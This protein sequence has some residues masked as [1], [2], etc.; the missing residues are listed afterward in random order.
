ME[1]IIIGSDRAAY[2]TGAKAAVTIASRDVFT[3]DDKPIKMDAQGKKEYRG[4]V[5]WGADNNLPN[6]IVEIVGNNSIG[7][8]SI[9][10]KIDVA[11]GSGVKIGYRNDKNIFEPYPKSQILKDKALTEIQ[12][13]LDDNNISDFLSE[14]ATDITWFNNGFVEFILDRNEGS[15]RKIVEITAKEAFFSRWETANERGIVENHFYSAKWPKK[16]KAEEYVVT[17]VLWGKNPANILLRK[18]GRMPDLQGKVKDEKKYVYIM[19][20]RM[21]SPGKLYYPRPAYYS[22]ISS[23]WMD[24]AN[25]IPK[26]KQAMMN[27]SMTIAYHIEIHEDYFPDIF[28]KEGIKTKK[29][30]E[31]RRK[32]EYEELNKFL[33]GYDNAGKTM[34]TYTKKVPSSG[35][36]ETVSMIKI[37][38][39]DKKIGG[40]YIEDSHEA[41]AMIYTAFRVHPNLIGVIPGKNPIN[42]SG[43]DKRE[44]LRIAQSLQGRLRAKLLQPLNVVKKVNGWPEEVEFAIPDIILTTLDQG[45][46][47]QS[48]TI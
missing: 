42:L 44:L 40:E 17:P 10:F 9:E 43:S 3:E 7:T 6:S 22:I 2:L 16:P 8:S 4:A 19:P 37:S 1:E 5:P 36:I 14:L 11:F 25:A 15:K 32:K 39:I 45:K 24:F 13:F 20:V 33:K 21:P 47:V 48:M 28:R 31:A 35:K 29:A 34:I 26:F 41:N 23:G 30:Q 38:V 18:M 46:E 12:N 27:N